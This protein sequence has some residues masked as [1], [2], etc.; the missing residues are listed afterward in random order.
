MLD[1]NVSEKHVMVCASE[2]L[3]EKQYIIV[4]LLYKDSPHSGIV[5][6]FNGEAFAYLNQCVHMP[7]ALNCERDTIFDEQRE[8]LRCSMHGI[9]YDPVTGA[10]LST[11]C[12]GER[13]NALR[14]R[15]IDGA[16][17][18][19]DKRVRPLLQRSTR[20]DPATT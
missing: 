10:S 14:L 6:R 2:Q 12:N 15:E 17:Y 7:R 1:I 9:V 13:L 3:G 20:T 8:L 5:F 16:I 4:D 19:R 18:I 11:M